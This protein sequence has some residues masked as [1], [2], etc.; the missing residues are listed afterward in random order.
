MKTNLTKEVLMLALCLIPAI[1]LQTI[2]AEIPDRV[3]THWNIQGEADKWG[4][5][6]YLIYL[7]VGLPLFIYLLLLIIPSID[8]RKKISLMGDKYLQLR[9]LLI[10]LVVGLNLAIVYS[11]AHQDSLFGSS[12]LIIITGLFLLA[13]GNYLKT[14]RPNYFV[15]IRTP[16]TLENETVWKDTHY[17]SGYVWMGSGALMVL[18]GLFVEAKYGFPAMMVLLIIMVLYSV[19]YSYWRFRQLKTVQNQS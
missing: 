15:G 13:F 7:S 5:K 11:A 8:P 10:G 3:P 2:W 16:W 9:I 14:I 18:I 19:I 17:M 4:H 1:Y 12:L 6:N